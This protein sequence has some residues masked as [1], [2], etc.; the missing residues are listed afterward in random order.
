MKYIILFCIL[1]FALPAVAQKGE[2]IKD[3]IY[4][5]TVINECGDT[6]FNLTEVVELRGGRKFTNSQPVGFD[7]NNPCSGIK[8][9]DTATLVN[10][11]ANPL[12]DYGRQ[13][14]LDATKFVFQPRDLKGFTGVNAALVRFG[15]PNMLKQIEKTFADSL[16]G[17][18]IL[19]RPGV[20]NA[21]VNVTKLA[22][23]SV[24][25][26]INAQNIFPFVVYSDRWLLLQDVAGTG[27][28]VDLYQ[29]EPGRWVSLL[30]NYQLVKNT[31]QI[32]QNSIKK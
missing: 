19:V 18:Y 14:A 5:S 22:N 4:F 3:T 2:V 31:R 32:V 30:G 27:Q 9:R 15:M 20:A 29:I 7:E 11:Y 26:R 25:I 17:S 8:A 10:F 23:G 12:I 24:R 28:H 21:T 1:V 16:V 6:V 13:R